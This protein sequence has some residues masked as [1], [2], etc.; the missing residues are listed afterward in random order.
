M[1]MG[2]EMGTGTGTGTGTKQTDSNDAAKE[3][4]KQMRAQKKHQWSTGPLPFFPIVLSNEHRDY[5]IKEHS[6]KQEEKDSTPS[7]AV[8]GVLELELGTSCF[9]HN[10]SF[11]RRGNAKIT[12][13]REIIEAALLHSK[14]S[15]QEALSLLRT[16]Y[17]TALTMAQFFQ[18]VCDIAAMLN[19]SFLNVVDF[20]PK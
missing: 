9:L 2:K 3:H 19:L 7:M 13:N 20:F 11:I 10:R 4:I 15:C 16:K 12:M 17:G 8:A 5:N 6:A 14:H 1:G 18:V